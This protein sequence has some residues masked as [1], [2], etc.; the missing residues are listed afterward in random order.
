MEL[1]SSYDGSVNI[2]LCD[3]LNKTRLINTRFSAMQNNT[4]QVTDHLNNNNFNIYNR[5]TFN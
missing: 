5:G 1:Q 3:N 4:Y 2:I